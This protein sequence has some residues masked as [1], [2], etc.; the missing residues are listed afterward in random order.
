MPLVFQAQ[1]VSPGIAMAPAV[2][3]NRHEPEDPARR[4]AEPA[5]ERVLLASSQVRMRSELTALRDHTLRDLGPIQAEIFDAHLS[6]VADPELAGLI[7]AIV[8]EGWDAPTAVFRACQSFIELL[9]ELEE[10]GQRS[11]A[12][13]LR[14]LRR[15]WLGLLSGK[16]CSG[17][18]VGTPCILVADDLTP[19]ETAGLDLAFVKGFLTAAG[20]R[21][22]H[23]SILA[24]S[25]GLPAATGAGAVL[26]A[27]QPGQLVAFDGRTGEVVLDP[28]AGQQ[29]RFL[30]VQ[31]AEAAERA[32]QKRYAALQTVTADG[33]HL[34]LAA[35][36][37]RVEDV[38]AVLGNGA[39]GVG[40]FR[41]E[42]LF[43]DRDR[44]PTEDEQTAVYTHVL[45][46]LSGRPVVIRTL[47]IG[48]DKVL[49][50]L[51]LDPELNPFL[52]VRA[53]RLCLGRPEL[54]RTQI[55][56]LLRSSPAGDL[57]VMVPMVALVEE[58][59]QVRA[60]F[61][62]EAAKLTAAGVPVAKFQLGIMV[63]IPAAA[64]NARALADVAD[65]FSLGTNDL[66]QYTMAADRMNDKLTHLYQPL[67][68]S[69]LRLVDLTVQGA[70]A[71]GRWVGVCGEMASDPEAALVLLGL[72]VDELS[73][74]AAGIP[75]MRE[76]LSRVDRSR[77][78]ATAHLALGMGTAAEV[79]TLVRS[80]HP[81]L[82]KEDQGEAP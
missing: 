12:E 50:Y 56:A 7:E 18:T 36:I 11:R 42:F 24:R 70:R 58:V 55:R 48:G 8:D 10:E 51:P 78:A 6:M 60:L 75:A 67:H 74:S 39:E 21:T 40:L 63:E 46:R 79:L 31:A 17:P 32:R 80:R 73:L 35:N 9:S 3:L 4:T 77:A 2:V 14:D 20:S 62:E 34:D 47:D 25:A 54:F 41:S 37:G 81:E 23:A 69:I 72:G 76:L 29:A 33:A 1:G 43:L 26:A 52:G 38:G 44:P 22:S 64:L 57:R 71:R 5:A 82:Q 45:A 66:I 13:D 28:D 59:A 27:V 68:P 65:F 53:V 49:P 61:A 15:R 30:A 19:S 16:A